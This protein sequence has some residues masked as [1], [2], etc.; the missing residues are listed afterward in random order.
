LDENDPSASEAPGERDDR[1]GRGRCR[2]GDLVRGAARD[3]GLGGLGL[4]TYLGIG[5]GA[6][7]VLA[8][9]AGALLTLRTRRRRACAVDGDEVARA[10]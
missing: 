9:A 10:R 1:R 6:P 5:G 3:R 4:A 8:I 2:G 7:F